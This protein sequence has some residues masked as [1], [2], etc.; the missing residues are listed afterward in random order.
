MRK[1]ASSSTFSAQNAANPR[2]SGVIDVKKY[3]FT[4]GRNCK[5][6]ANH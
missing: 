6:K 5:S 1:Y 2:C 4:K 3:S